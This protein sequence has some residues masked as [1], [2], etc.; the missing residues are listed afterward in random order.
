MKVLT[1]PAITALG[2]TTLCLM[3]GLEPLISSNHLLVYHL[4]DPWMTAFAPIVFTTVLLWVILFGLL[5]LV[6]ERSERM[7]SVVWSGL[8][9]LLPGVLLKNISKIAGWKLYPHTSVMVLAV[10]AG[11]LVLIQLAWRPSFLSVAT[12]ARHIAMTILGF[13]AL[14]GIVMLGQLL[15][16]GWQA[17]NLNSLRP[18]HR[19]VAA[20]AAV[21]HSRIIWIIFDELSFHQAYEHRVA[22]LQLP[23]FDQLASQATMFRHVVPVGDR[24]RVVVPALMT[25][26]PVDRVRSS[27]AGDLWMHDG[28]NGRWQ[29][30]D[31]SRTI[32]QRAL[33]D[34][35]ST[36]I[37][38]WYN[39]YCRILPS[40]L[41]RCFWTYHDVD[42]GVGIG[43]ESVPMQLSAPIREMFQRAKYLV[44]GGHRS[45]PDDVRAAERHIED[46]KQ[47]YAVADE[48]LNDSS[49][50]FLLLHMPVPHPWGFYDRT[51]ETFTTGKSSYIDNLALADRYLTHVHDLLVERG[52]WNSSTLVV[53]GD[54]S[55][56]TQSLWKD[57]SGWTSED[58]AAS[59]GDQFDER[60]AYMVKLPN[61]QRPAEVNVP[62]QA[63][64]TRALFEELLRHN[65]VT[66]DDLAGWAAR[67]P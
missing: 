67:N 66:P 10:C 24:T 56:R 35:Y 34:G 44:S 11:L 64:R 9:L 49:L 3:S 65:L 37:A 23:A 31:A 8:L 29:P 17:R 27:A 4:S 26:I 59:Q 6:E 16:C 12:S 7:L 50:T 28:S 18:L 19:Q 46:Y 20:R 33:E 45:T 1:H 54:H 53:M 30:F 40:V 57:T 25:G 36:G 62:F 38:G 58:E 2:M 15:W 60:P 43:E 41:D 52:E 14:S 48:M 32:F 21:S 39:P 22:G 55:W 63:I 5:K 51:R 42:T 61:Q 47:L 13:V